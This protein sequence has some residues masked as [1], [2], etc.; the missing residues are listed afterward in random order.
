MTPLTAGRHLSIFMQR[1][2]SVF[3][4]KL[5]S[6]KKIEVSNQLCKD[7]KNMFSRDRRNKICFL[8]PHL[9]RCTTLHAKLS[10]LSNK[11]PHSL[12]KKK[13]RQKVLGSP[14]TKC[15]QT[16]DMHTNHFRQIKSFSL[17]RN[18]KFRR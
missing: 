18:K 7:M 4:N 12:K 15:A 1:I 9:L 16:L 10:K 8:S 5:F 17:T 14:P 3:R 6:F 11:T 13:T 2:T